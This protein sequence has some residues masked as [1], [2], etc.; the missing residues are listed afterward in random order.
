MHRSLDPFHDL[1]SDDPYADALLTAA[2]IGIITGDTDAGGVPVGTVRPSDAIK[3]GEVAKIIVLLEENRPASSV[4]EQQA[5]ASVASQAPQA[6]GM[7]YQVKSPFLH[8][9]SD[10]DF[11][12]GLVD[13]L[14]EGDKVTVTEVIDGFW[15]K[16][17]LQDGQEGYA[18]LR[19][20]QQDAP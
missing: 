16:V 17:Q 11:N 4:A 14:N 10:A 3:R 1:S 19:Y 18:A 5:P 8:V 13:T 9:R 7:P 6:G 12:S 15:A 2:H 20:L